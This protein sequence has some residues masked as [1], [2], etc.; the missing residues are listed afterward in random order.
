MEAYCKVIANHEIGMAP[1]PN[2]DVYPEMA[3]RL[4]HF[5]TDNGGVKL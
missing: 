3:H 1:K 4:A 5:N 2:T